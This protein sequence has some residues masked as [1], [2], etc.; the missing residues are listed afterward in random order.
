MSIAHRKPARP[1]RKPT[2]ALIPEDDGGP[3]SARRI[4]ASSVEPRVAECV[5][6]R[7]P[8]LVGR[9]LVR[10]ASGDERTELWAPTLQG[11]VVRE[12]DRVL[13]LEA[14][15]ADEPVVIGVVDGF[16]RRDEAPRSA[17]PSVELKADEML[18]V[19]T[20]AGDTLLEIARNADGPVIRLLQRDTQVELPGKLCIRADQI[21]LRARR[22]GV[23]I[24]ATDDIVVRG[25]TVHLN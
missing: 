19:V 23:Q 20:E 2:L 10:W 15:G 17:G 12:G 18:Q 11:L 9:V 6:A 8:T 3:A 21:E 1:A 13:L 5:D 24:E 22:G 7:H 16:R 25:E 14:A 4:A